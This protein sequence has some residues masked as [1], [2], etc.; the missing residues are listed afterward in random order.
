[1]QAHLQRMP[2]L[3]IRFQRSLSSQPYILPLS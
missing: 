2:V 1:V 3:N